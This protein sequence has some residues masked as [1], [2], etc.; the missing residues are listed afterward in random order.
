MSQQIVINSSL[1][2]YYKFSDKGDKILIF[3][4]GWRSEGS[5]WRGVGNALKDNVSIYALDMP[6]FGK[7]PL[8]SSFKIQDYIDIV[9]SFI[10]KLELKNVILVGHSF[11]GRVAIKLSATQPELVEKIVLVDSAGFVQNRKNYTAVAKMVKP[12]FKPAF[13]QS[14]RKWIYKK[15]G[16]EDYV[17]TP[18]LK[19]TFLNIINEDL[20]GYL[21]EIKK[22]TLIIWGEDDKDTPVE[23]AKTMKEEIK[24]S[25]LVILSGAGHYSFIDSALEFN[26]SLKKFIHE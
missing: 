11:G 20:S 10:K 18:E 22:P 9:S 24:N 1:V 23:F 14:S 25:K 2:N 8:E 16:A 19:E 13:M 3:L 6:G 5:I 21:S 15:I 4:H 7:S 17:T 26:D 12:I